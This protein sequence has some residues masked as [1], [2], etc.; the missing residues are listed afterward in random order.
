MFSYTPLVSVLLTEAKTWDF[1]N[2]CNLPLSE[3]RPGSTDLDVKKDG[4]NLINLEIF[5]SFESL[6]CKGC[7]LAGGSWIFN[8][9]AHL[10]P[11]PR[12]IFFLEIKKEKKKQ[13]E[14]NE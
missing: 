8:V 11:P 13:L 5:I 9:Y 3:E 14:N 7:N 4:N 12:I 1:S 6:Y 10:I 2:D